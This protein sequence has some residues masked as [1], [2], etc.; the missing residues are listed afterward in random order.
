MN[1]SECSLDLNLGVVIG[2]CTVGSLDQIYN[3]RLGQGRRVICDLACL[4]DIFGK[5]YNFV[6]TNIIM[7]KGT[8]SRKDLFLKTN[9]NQ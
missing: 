6:A 3:P 2:M 4:A 8:V 7:R 5:V 9:K 1:V